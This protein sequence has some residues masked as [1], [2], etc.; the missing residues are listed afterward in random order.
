MKPKLNSYQKK[1]DPKM[2]QFQNLPDEIILKVLT[3]L[4]VK[5]LLSCGQASKRIRAVSHDKSLYQKIDLAGKKV[6]TIFL[7]T[8]INKG[9]KELSLSGAQLEGSEFNL[10]EKSQLR[11]LNLDFCDASVTNLEIL[12][13]SCLKIQKISDKHSGHSPPYEEIFKNNRK[14][15]KLL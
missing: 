6:Q 9:C 3:H 5:D 14:S 7:E 8:I 13:G 2:S 15:V 1:F 4:K 11:C 10:N 12:T